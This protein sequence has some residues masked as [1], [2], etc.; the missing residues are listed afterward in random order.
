MLEQTEMQKTPLHLTKQFIHRIRSSVEYRTLS[1]N[2]VFEAQ[3]AKLQ[4]SQNIHQGKRCFIIGNGPSLNQTDLSKL[5][6]EFTFGLN[7]IYLL[8]DQLGFSTSYYVCTNRLVLSQFKADIIA[9]VPSPKFTVW[10][11][12]QI[13][14]TIPD[15]HFIYRHNYA[16]FFG[17]I[18]KGVWGGA[19]V[20]YVAM[21]IAYFMGFDEVILIGVDHSFSTQGKPH[22]TVVSGGADPNHFASNYF[23]KGVKWQLPDLVTSEYAYSLA[24]QAYQK[25]GKRIVDAT[26]GGKLKVFPK[27]NYTDLW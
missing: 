7:R 1:K 9:N 19:T 20:T 24:N 2:P 21:Q 26:I 22:K 13:A 25:A 23:G 10:E 27:I 14:N 5:R 15:M 6:D 12:Y 16:D 8:F 4:S 18:V 17:N 11:H 3:K